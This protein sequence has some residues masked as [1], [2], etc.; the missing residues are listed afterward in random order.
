[1]GEGRSAAPGSHE[2][3]PVLN[4]ESIACDVGGRAIAQV[5][6]ERVLQTCRVPLSAELGG[7]MWPADGAGGPGENPIPGD[8]STD[9][10]EAF[11][12][13]PSPG[14]AGLCELVQLVDGRLQRR[15]REVAK[16]VEWAG[17]RFHGE[18]DADDQTNAG[19]ICFAGRLVNATQRVVV[20]DRE[21]PYSARCGPSDE[22]CRRQVAIGRD[23]VR[24]KVDAHR[25]PP[26]RRRP[27]RMA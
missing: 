10:A 17:H 4:R 26:E 3:Q 1:M 24:V 11:D 15:A 18:F 20:G 13:S 9:L 19:D 25:A 5:S 12:D 8:R 2:R 21:R 27:D 22:F 7:D 14:P 23:R 6:G 16:Q